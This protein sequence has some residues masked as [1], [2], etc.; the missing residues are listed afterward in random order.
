MLTTNCQDLLSTNLDVLLNCLECLAHDFNV[1]KEEASE[2]FLSIFNCKDLI[3][4]LTNLFYLDNNERCASNAAFIVGSLAESKEGVKCIYQLTERNRNNKLLESLASM[5]S[6]PDEEMVMNS[7]GCLATLAESS[8]FRMKMITNNYFFD[9]LLSHLAELLLCKNF[10]TSAN[11]AL[12]LARL[13][14]SDEAC[15]KLLDHKYC[16]HIIKHLIISLG[17]DQEGRGMNS[18]FTVGRLLSIEK[19][20][21]LLLRSPYIK[22]MVKSLMLMLV[23]GKL[24]CKKNACFATSCLATTGEGSHLVLT[25]NNLTSCISCLLELCANCDDDEAAWFAAMTLRTLSAN[26]LGLYKLR[27]FETLMNKLQ[28]MVKNKCIFFEVKDEI[29]KTLETLKTVKRP[30]KPQTSDIGFD[31]ATVEWEK[32]QFSDDIDITYHLYL[33]SILK[34]E[35]PKTKYKITDLEANTCYKVKVKAKVIDK[36]SLI[37]EESEFTTVQGVPERPLNLRTVMTYPTK[38]RVSWQPPEK[39]NGTVLGYTV[40][41]DKRMVEQ[42]VENSYTVCR[43]H[44]SNCYLVEVS[45][46]TSVG[47][48]KR[49]ETIVTTTELSYH[50]PEKPQVSVIGRNEMTVSWNSPANPVGRFFRYELLANQVAMYSGVEKSHRATNLIANTEYSFTVVAITSEGRC[51]S[52]ATKKKTHRCKTQSEKGRIKSKTF[53]FQVKTQNKETPAQPPKYPLNADKH[54]TAKKK[55]KNET[56]NDIPAIQVKTSPKRGNFI[57]HE[58]NFN[59]HLIDSLS[60]SFN[61]LV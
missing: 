16:S 59:K 36:E 43:L 18:A 55:L 26:S 57:L 1:N 21:K 51:E 54:N 22:Q 58:Q 3:W 42:T 7:T 4:S 34:Y 10:A 39:P 28:Q 8:I 29:S 32:F 45:A 41:L 23:E 44:P 47:S 37:S 12:L 46:H 6:S 27:N 20:S 2:D 25:S 35:G 50:A 33:D 15:N 31:Y 30:S 19:G 49:A 56:N 24:S 13:T 14:M 5:L 40:Y 17:V 38:I 60:I 52:E 61:M 11:V 53:S 48:G 9:I